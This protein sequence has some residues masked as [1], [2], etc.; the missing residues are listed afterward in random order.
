MGKN[1]TIGVLVLALV[2]LGA[3]AVITKKELTK[4]TQKTNE[5]IKETSKETP[6]SSIK[7]SV[8]P[9]GA[10]KVQES[11]DKKYSLYASFN[12]K[13]RFEA[14]DA[15]I[16]SK[17]RDY[18]NFMYELDYFSPGQ[19]MS[20]SPSPFIG[21]ALYLKDN[22]TGEIVEIYKDKDI[23][24]MLLTTALFSPDSKRIVYTNTNIYSYDI[25]ASAS[26]LLSENKGCDVHYIKQFSPDG[27]TAIFNHHCQEG[28]G[29][30]IAQ[31]DPWKSLSEWFC[32]IGCS[33]PVPLGYLNKDFVISSTV[34][35]EAPEEFASPT[36]IG[37]Y[38]LDG[39]LVSKLKTYQNNSSTIYAEQNVG[40]STDTAFAINVYKY[41]SNTK[42][43]IETLKVSKTTFSLVN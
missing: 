12:V 26:T 41:I 38:R 18:M 35:E 40:L 43:F 24:E 19:G 16:K 33:A 17:D 30:F 28:G 20:L 4:V 34:P 31:L 9:E 23:K 2:G 29:G 8:L 37:V 36:D 10:K 27:K 11:S 32:Y 42:T 5:E 7:V 3:Y 21:D 22:A 6:A 1:I 14:L 15:K 39:G 25:S 13:N